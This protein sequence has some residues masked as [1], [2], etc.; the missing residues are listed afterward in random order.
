MTNWDGVTPPKLK[1]HSQR[2][3]GLM[4]PNAR[5]PIYRALVDAL[6]RSMTPAERIDVDK[7]LDR[8]GVA[9]R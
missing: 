6:G 2:K 4:A 7:C 3:E 8:V 5:V 9:K 1:N